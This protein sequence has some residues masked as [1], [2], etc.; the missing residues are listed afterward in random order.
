MLPY[1]IVKLHSEQKMYSIYIADLVVLVKDR[2]I[3]SYFFMTWITY[4]VATCINGSNKQIIPLPTFID[5]FREEFTD[6]IHRNLYPWYSIQFT[7]SLGYFYVLFYQPWYMY[8]NINQI[9]L[10]QKLC[11]QSGFGNT[12]CTH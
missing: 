12:Y 10:Y 9:S 3:I 11:H 7:L 8:K 5:C 1:I 6:T 4:I 2:W